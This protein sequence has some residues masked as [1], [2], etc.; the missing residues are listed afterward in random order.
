MEFISSLITSWWMSRRS[1]SQNSLSQTMGDDG[2][3]DMPETM[4]RESVREHQD[5]RDDN[6]DENEEN[7]VA[8]VDIP[9]SSPP[10][11]QSRRR[12]R[13]RATDDNHTSLVGDYRPGSIRRIKLT[14]FLTYDAVEFCPGPRYVEVLLFSIVS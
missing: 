2:D 1:A 11:T 7:E 14:N 4:S 8:A 12:R 13:D 10:R 3:D 9:R 6:G 5:E